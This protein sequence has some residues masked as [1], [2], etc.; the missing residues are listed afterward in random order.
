MH[1]ESYSEQESK[2]HW[3]FALL[4]GIAGLLILL[5]F[6]NVRS[7][8]VDVNYTST[9]ASLSNAAPYLTQVSTC[10][11]DP[12]GSSNC[13]AN[14]TSFT[15]TECTATN[16]TCTGS[17]GDYVIH[18]TGSYTDPNGC[19]EVT[20]AS[21]GQGM[22]LLEIATSTANCTTYG[23]NGLNCVK[24]SN[25]N[26]GSGTGSCSF[27]SC[28]GAT[29]DGTFNCTFPIR[30]NS[31]PTASWLAF[32][33]LYDGTATSS[34]TTYTSSTFTINAVLAVGV[35]PT[36][37]FSASTGGNLVAYDGTVGSFGKSTSSDTSLVVYNTGN[38]AGTTFEFFGRATTTA[39]VPTRVFNCTT[40]SITATNFKWSLTTPVSFGT[41]SSNTPGSNAEWNAGTSTLAISTA[42]DVSASAQQ[43]VH[44]ELYVPA[45][46]AGTCTGDLYFTAV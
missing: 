28:T 14:V 18:I 22:S 13:G 4:L 32:P 5:I 15:P 30:Y 11:T 7:K 36:L 21:S 35:T 34:Y 40:G 17:A 33:F 27:S 6:I 9:T 19:S 3:I 46:Q 20:G 26:T 16:G 10:V 23:N 1:N 43:T 29:T 31:E 37:T 42:A 38:T 39:S 25:L 8:A 44:L 45:G 41:M 12:G 2:T 24:Y